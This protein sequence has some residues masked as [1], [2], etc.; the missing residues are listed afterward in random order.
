MAKYCQLCKRKIGFFD[1][2]HYANLDDIFNDHVKKSRANIICDECYC[3]KRKERGN[4]LYKEA[5]AFISS[6][7]YFSNTNYQKQ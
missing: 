5:L 1:E 2:E 7:T 6:N 3:D 4:E